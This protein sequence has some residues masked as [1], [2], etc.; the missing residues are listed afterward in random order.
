MTMFKITANLIDDH[1]KLVKFVYR[2]G[3]CLKGCDILAGVPTVTAHVNY[4]LRDQ[5]VY[6]FPVRRQDLLRD[7]FRGFIFQI[8]RNPLAL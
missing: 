5:V 7:G 1:E 8:T 6:L 3:C 2:F 4:R